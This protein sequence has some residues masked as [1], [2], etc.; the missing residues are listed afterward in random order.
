[1]EE[2]GR[3]PVKSDRTASRII[4]KETVIVLLDEQQTLVLN[5]VG[6]RIWEIMDGEKDLDELTRII[7]SEF[8]VA[9]TDALQDITNFI[10]ELEGKGAVAVK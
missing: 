3:T 7:T 8:D 4:D 5:D 9:Y 1:M 10:E 6:S 2:K